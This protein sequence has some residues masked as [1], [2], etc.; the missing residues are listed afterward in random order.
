M[1]QSQAQ[2][3]DPLGSM[4]GSSCS[5]TPLLLGGQAEDSCGQLAPVTITNAAGSTAGWSLTGQVSDF[6]DPSA[7]SST[8]CDTPADYSELCIPGGDLGWSP[9]ATVDSV[10]P[11][12]SAVVQPGGAVG[13]APMTAANPS[14][15]GARYPLAWDL[16]PSV[17]APGITVKPPAGLHDTPQVLC[18]STTASSGGS[19]TCGA[20]LILPVPA[21]TAA[22]SGPGFQATLTLTL[23]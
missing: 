16:W 21:S 6:V 7:P 13:P 17:S 20:G 14:L 1:Q 11:G 2:P 19:F 4:D 8:T 5:A 23:S 15:P 12:S 9:T 22:S 3:I 18:Q 10:L